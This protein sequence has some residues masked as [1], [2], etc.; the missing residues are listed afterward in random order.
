LHA[1]HLDCRTRRSGLGSS[2]GM[3]LCAVL[4][5]LAVAVPVAQAAPGVSPQAAPQA[6]PQASSGGPSP[7]PSPQ[8]SPVQ[9][10]AG[11]SASASTGPVVPLATS[12][13]IAVASPSSSSHP[14]AASPVVSTPAI[15]TASPA[16]R[17][18]RAKA[19][20]VRERARWVSLAT[21]AL[22][23]PWRNPFAVGAAAGFRSG[24]PSRNGLLLLF[25]AVALAILALASTSML[26]LLR[27]MDEVVG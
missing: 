18:T 10:A 15:R 20:H 13:G 25:G 19:L 26:R 16:R 6:A 4:L 21:R 2:A 24:T 7:D 12:S 22:T 17:S 11:G 8:A 5:V 14:E 1:R 9:Q 23:L 3:A 27:G